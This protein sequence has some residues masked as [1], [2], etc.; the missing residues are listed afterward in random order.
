MSAAT[1]T[2]PRRFIG[3][4]ASANGGYACGTV[5]LALTDGPAEA[6]LRMPPPVDRPLRVEVSDGASA[7]YDGDTV[8]A[9]ARAA[10]V[11]LAVPAPVSFDDAVA[12]SNRFDVSEYQASHPF[13]GCFTC[14]PAREE[15]DGLRLFPSVV[16]RPEPIVA[17][18]WI[19][20]GSLA[21][22]DG[23][24]EPTVLWATL[25]CPSAFGATLTDGEDAHDENPAVLGRMQ[26]VIARRPAPDD[27]LV[28]GGWPV[29]REGRKR[30][31]GSVIWSDDGE[32]LAYTL[33]TWITLSDEQLEAFGVGG[34]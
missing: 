22:A 30:F 2:I 31:A 12:A 16:E 27:R 1:V 21:T 20:D 26:T 17:I 18:P 4:P 19:P 29:G 14:G 5:A 23:R 32:A 3:P 9:E 8:V 13:P 10:E 28:V 24:I 15:G 11:E 7:L 6:T 25:D 33:A 34:P